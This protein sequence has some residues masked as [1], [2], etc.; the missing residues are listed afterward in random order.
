MT[1]MMTSMVGCGESESM[2]MRRDSS[3]TRSRSAIRA[4]SSF[5]P[6]ISARRRSAI[7]AR[8]KLVMCLWAR[9]H[10]ANVQLQGMHLA[11]HNAHVTRRLFHVADLL[12][13]PCGTAHEGPVAARDDGLSEMNDRLSEEQPLRLMHHRAGCDHLALRDGRQ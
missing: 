5:W 12:V 10:T 3:S 7:P 4:R 13:E 1:A 11:R 9:A 6:P 2:L 8:S